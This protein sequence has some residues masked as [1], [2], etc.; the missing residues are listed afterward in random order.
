M[1]K[2]TKNAANKVA[3]VNW[4]RLVGSIP[5]LPQRLQRHVTQDLDA[6]FLQDSSSFLRNEEFQIDRPAG[7]PVLI[8]QLGSALTAFGSSL[9]RP[10]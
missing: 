6:S 10:G 8:G 2:V 4:V 3:L 9:G 5:V 1:S 7:V